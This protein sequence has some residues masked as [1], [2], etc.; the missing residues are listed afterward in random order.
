[1]QDNPQIYSFHFQISSQAQPSQPL[2][3]SQNLLNLFESFQTQLQQQ[4]QQPQHLQQSQQQQFHHFQQSQQ[5]Q[6]S[7]Q[8]QQSHQLP[9]S[10]TPAGFF[11]WERLIRKMT[12]EAT[13]TGKGRDLTWKVINLRKAPQALYHQ[14]FTPTIVKKDRFITLLKTKAE[15]QAIFGNLQRSWGSGER[16]VV[17]GPMKVTWSPKSLHIIFRYTVYLPNGKEA[18]WPIVHRANSKFKLF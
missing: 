7:Q 3:P 18:F 11:L 8:P 6:Q 2:Q 10:Q 14:F 12:R 9:F 4:L 16:A 15:I 5:A 17:E 1:M 13:G